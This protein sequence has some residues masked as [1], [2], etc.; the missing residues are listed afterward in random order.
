VR[1]LDIQVLREGGAFLDEAEAGSGFDPI[2]ALIA[3]AVRRK[4]NH[5]V[6]S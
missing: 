1:R 4:V 5:R 6:L 2:R 3:S